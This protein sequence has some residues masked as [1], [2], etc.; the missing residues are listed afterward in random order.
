MKK[1]FLLVALCALFMGCSNVTSSDGDTSGSANTISTNASLVGTWSY[2]I[3]SMSITYTFTETDF[4]ETYVNNSASTTTIIS[5][6]YTKDDNYIYF[7]PTSC[8]INNVDSTDPNDTVSYFMEYSLSSD[9]R[10]IL[11]G[12]IE[13]AKQ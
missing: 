13:L 1:M 2:S 11:T 7:T 8:K 3:A 5:G 9:K 6:T 4:T 12:S 10:K